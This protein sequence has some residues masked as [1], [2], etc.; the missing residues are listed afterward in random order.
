[1]ATVSIF[2]VISLINVLEHLLRAD[3]ALNE[4]LTLMVHIRIVQ[5]VCSVGLW[6]SI[7]SWS[8]FLKLK[9]KGITL[10]LTWVLV[11][12]FSW[13]RNGLSEKRE[14]E[15]SLLEQMTPVQDTDWHFQKQWSHS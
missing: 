6:K 8:V 14:Q 5:L 3:T 11:T 15:K 2:I 13:P 7:F 10:D 9:G 12:V 4:D 1:M